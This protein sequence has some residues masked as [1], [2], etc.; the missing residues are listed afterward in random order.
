VSAV[1]VKIPPFWLAD[2]QVWFAQMEAQFTM[3]NITNQW[4]KF[5]HV[6]S[7]LAHEFATD[8]LDLLLQPLADTAYDILHAQLI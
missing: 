2:L 3:Q 7:T 1:T 5:D 4:T 8:V 6:V